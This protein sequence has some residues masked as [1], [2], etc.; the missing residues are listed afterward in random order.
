MASESAF[1]VSKLPNNSFELLMVTVFQFEYIVDELTFI[2]SISIL[3]SWIEHVYGVS[4]LPENCDVIYYSAYLYRWVWV[5]NSLS[6]PSREGMVNRI[7]T[8]YLD[9][10]IS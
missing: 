4:Q 6:K 5:G 7:S 3:N 1:I 8:G 2:L 10:L 9:I